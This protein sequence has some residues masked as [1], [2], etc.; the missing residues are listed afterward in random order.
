[1][2]PLRFRI[3]VLKPG[4]TFTSQCRLCQLLEPEI[5]NLGFRITYWASNVLFPVVWSLYFK[6]EFMVFPLIQQPNF[7]PT[8]CPIWHGLFPMIVLFLS[9]NV[10]L[11]RFNYLK[12]FLCSSYASY[13][14]TL[15]HFNCFY[16]PVSV[17]HCSLCKNTWSPAVNQWWKMYSDEAWWAICVIWEYVH[18]KKSFTGPIS[19]I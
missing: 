16:F 10:Q 5:P 13:I 6:A 4:F 8:L 2:S 11:Q 1:M 3:D 17:L 14:S 15:H 12:I 7:S 9:P 18:S 19:T